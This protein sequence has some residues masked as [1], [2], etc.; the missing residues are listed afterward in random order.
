MKR[1]TKM[2]L[3]YKDFVPALSGLIGKIALVSSFAMVWA[4]ELLIT[5]PYFVLENVRIEILI[6]SIITLITACLYPS[7]APVGTLAPLVVMIPAMSI[8]GV[9]PLILG[10][11]VGIVGVVIIKI[12]LFNRLV[13]LA[14]FTCKTS[15]T[16]TFGVSGIWMSASKLYSFFAQE[17]QVFWILIVVLI[18]IYILLQYYQ[19]N[20]LVIPIFSL[21]AFVIPA[22]FGLGYKI[23]PVNVS[24]NL[25]PVYWWNEMWGI[26]FGLNFITI[27]KTIPF[28]FFII[29]LWTIDTVSI[30][31]IREASYERNEEKEY[32]DIPQSFMVVCIRNIIG[33]FCGGAQTG[34]LW[35]SFLIPLYMVKRPMRTC[36]IL[37]GIAGIIASLTVVPIQ[38]MSY[39]PLVWSVLL[40]GIFTPF[41]WVSLKNIINTRKKAT[42][43]SILLFALLGISINPIITWIVSVVYEKIEARKVGID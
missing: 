38:M 29:L 14:G 17:Q 8:F 7:A 12:G 23:V 39:T 11:T 28:A 31:T 33:T 35:R 22:L 34:S 43:I 6:G 30:Q 15:I 27:I 3:C 9:H 13:N 4:Q 26:G 36:A 32:M 40:F 1:I 18:I 19:K 41:T 10:M 20:W 42:K 37:M 25:S 21:V 16:L 24:L 5:H 2:N